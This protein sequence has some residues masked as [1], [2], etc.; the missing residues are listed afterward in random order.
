MISGDLRSSG[1]PAM[2]QQTT[3]VSSAMVTAITLAAGR[4]PKSIAA[5]LI[6]SS[7]ANAAIW[8]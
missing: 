2:R 4:A 5:K 7:V 6:A 1:T 3:C 8:K